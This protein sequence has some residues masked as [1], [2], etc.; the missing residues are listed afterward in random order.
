MRNEWRITWADTADIGLK[1]HMIG[2]KYI[3]FMANE[4]GAASPDKD[5]QWTKDL[6]YRAGIQY[7]RFDGRSV[8]K[9]CRS[10]IKAAG[11]NVTVV[12]LVY[13]LAQ[14]AW[15]R[16]EDLGIPDKEGRV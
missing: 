10:A 7:Y 16:R 8:E 5:W 14:I 9:A 11:L 15:E 4:I 6:Y 13:E 12:E 2:T 1:E 3:R